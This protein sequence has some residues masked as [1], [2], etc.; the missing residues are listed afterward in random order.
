VSLDAL[1]TLLVRAEEIINQRLIAIDD[2]LQ[3][4]T[5]IKL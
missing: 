4:I 3:V 1:A 5:P 2:N